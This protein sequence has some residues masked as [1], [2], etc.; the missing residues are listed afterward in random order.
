MEHPTPVPENPEKKLHGCSHSWNN[1]VSEKPRASTWQG[2]EEG[3]V[4]QIR[5]VICPSLCIK[6]SD[7]EKQPVDELASSAKFR[8]RI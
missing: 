3:M 2:R 7:W 4:R 8:E 6:L 1:D 5:S